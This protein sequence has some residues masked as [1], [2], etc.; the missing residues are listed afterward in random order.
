M[1]NA[2]P[3]TRSA[4]PRVLTIEEF[5]AA[6]RVHRTT[7]YRWLRR[8]RVPA[9]RI[10]NRYLIPEAAVRALLTAAPIKSLRKVKPKRVA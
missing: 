7:A 3:A 1:K 10:G 8:K 2:N 6:T 5:T 4:L 9:L